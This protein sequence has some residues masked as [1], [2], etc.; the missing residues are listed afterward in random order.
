MFARNYCDFFSQCRHI[1]TI[2]TKENCYVT[3]RIPT[4]VQPE[5]STQDLEADERINAFFRKVAG[6]DL[7]IDWKELQDVL[8]FALKRGQ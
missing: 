2:R 8:N 1:T 3:L 7:E 4:K 6:D 5:D